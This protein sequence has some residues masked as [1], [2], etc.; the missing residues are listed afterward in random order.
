MEGLRLGDSSA[1]EQPPRA[2]SLIHL[3]SFLL[4]GQ[5]WQDRASADHRACCAPAAR[6]CC[7][8]S[9]LSAGGTSGGPHPSSPACQGTQPPWGLPCPGPSASPALAAGPGCSTRG[10]QS[11]HTRLQGRLPAS[12]PRVPLC[13]GQASPPHCPP[14]PPA[15][16]EPHS[17]L[18]PGEIQVRKVDTSDEGWA[19]EAAG[20][21]PAGTAAAWGGAAKT[22]QGPGCPASARKAPITALGPQ[23]S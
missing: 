14:A 22:Q 4:A 9:S 1:R 8:R 7:A 20:A 6:G 21:P 23:R 18:C 15:S 5:R 2:P 10:R 11:Q 17:A 19:L 3:R 13:R 12:L 16:S